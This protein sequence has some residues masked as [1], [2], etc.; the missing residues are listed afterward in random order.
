MRIVL[1]LSLISMSLAANAFH[2]LGGNI[3]F[4]YNNIPNQYTVK[5]TKYRDCSGIPFYPSDTICIRSASCNYNSYIVV[6][7]DSVLP[8][9]AC[10]NMPVPWSNCPGGGVY[11]KHIST[12]QL[13]LPF[14]CNDWELVLLE[15][16]SPM[17]FTIKT[18]FDNLNFPNNSSP[19]FIGEPCFYG[20]IQTL[21]CYSLASSDINN[22]TLI[23]SKEFIDISSNASCPAIYAP[24]FNNQS[25]ISMYTQL[26]SVTGMFCFNVPLI[27]YGISRYSVSDLSNSIKKSTVYGYN[28][29]VLSGSNNCT[30]AIHETTPELLFTIFPSFA[31]STIELLLKT[32]THSPIT[33]NIYN[34]LSQKV[35]VIHSFN[36]DKVILS[37]AD[38]KSGIYLLEVQSENNSATTK[39][40]KK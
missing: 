33:I 38:F 29:I 17:S 5:L 7:E 20:C 1:L 25:D 30:T 23:Y 26:D 31:T 4:S 39:F 24:D 14:A 21:L 22:D 37:V 15:S 10:Y 12:G 9:G 13:N 34:S 35:N 8:L 18:T 36:Q 11:E 28:A 2:F 6:L 19:T 16:N 32:H 27:I 40:V 3:T